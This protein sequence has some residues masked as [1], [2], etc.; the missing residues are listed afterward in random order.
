MVIDDADDEEE[1]NDDHDDDHDHDHDNGVDDDDGDDGDNGDDDDDGDSDDKGDD[2]DDDGGGDGDGGNGGHGHG[3]GHG[4]DHDHD[5]DHDDAQCFGVRGFV[6]RGTTLTSWACRW[7]RSSRAFRPQ[8][9]TGEKS[10]VL[11]VARPRR[12]ECA[13]DVVALLF[14]LLRFRSPGLAVARFGLWVGAIVQI[15]GHQHIHT[16]WKPNT[17]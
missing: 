11:G 13:V 15:R 17:T 5:L 14:L 8:T 16:T 1:E 12:R 10:N 9:C 2:D 6:E 3:H 4:N 7:R